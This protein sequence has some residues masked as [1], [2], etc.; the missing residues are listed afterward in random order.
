[1]IALGSLVAVASV[2][3]I[4]VFT[5]PEPD[6]PPAQLGPPSEEEPLPPPP[7]EVLAAV[8]VVGLPEALERADGVA[9]L[10]R[11]YGIDV[12]GDLEVVASEVEVT[13]A[14]L[15]GRS[16]VGVVSA[17][18]PAAT[19]EGLVALVDDLGLVDA[20]RIVALT[21]GADRTE[22][23]PVRELLDQ[24]VAALD[25]ATLRAAVSSAAAGTPLDEVAAELVTPSAAVP[26]GEVSGPAQLRVA[27]WDG[28]LGALLAAIAV[29]TLERTGVEVEV[30]PIGGEG[31]ADVV[32]AVSEG[33][34]DAALVI[35]GELPDAVELPWTR[36]LE[37]ARDAFQGRFEGQVTLGA[38]LGPDDV[39]LRYLVTEDVAARF[40]VARLSDLIGVAPATAPVDVDGGGVREDG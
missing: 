18:S 5:A 40:G 23:A 33:Q 27:S 29:A 13:A 37:A 20:H 32:A 34:A 1:M 14:L 16:V 30:I 2:G 3:S 12:T 15:D 4:G 21:A 17:V 19:A 10:A 35:A 39:G 22:L 6:G 25:L 11:V 9:G 8:A 28:P 31:A 36:N 7:D 26:N 38:V 24:Q